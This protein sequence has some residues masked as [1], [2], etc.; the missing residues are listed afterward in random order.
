MVQA[1]SR[2]ARFR[3]SFQP[4][5]WPFWAV[6]LTAI[7][8]VIASGWSWSGFALAVGLYWVRMFFVTAGYHRYFSHRSFKTSRPFQFLLALACSSTAQKGILW[9]AGH[10]RR[11]HKYSDHEGDIHSV[12]LDGGWWSHVGWIVG[13]DPAFDEPDLDRVKDLTR[14]PELR[15]IDRN[16]VV[17]TLA[18]P[19][20]LFLAGGWHAVLWGFFVGTVMTWHGSFSINSLSHLIGR[21]RYPTSDESRN[22]FLLALLTCGE[23]WHNNHHHYMTSA[24]QG[25][26]WYEID[27]TYY[28]L[29]MLGWFGLVWDLRVP[30]V[31][32]VRGEPAPAR[33]VVDELDAGEGPPG[34]EIQRAA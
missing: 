19:A 15:W 31:H 14:Y 1:V 9:W 18:V 33:I 26:R 5:S 27:M 13:C 34:A 8:G 20:I 12:K 17:P 23:G 3:R 30:P 21:R 29:R 7:I 4:K 22:S 10:H 28:V 32:V 25:W 11:H 6:H 24:N 16:W 2:G